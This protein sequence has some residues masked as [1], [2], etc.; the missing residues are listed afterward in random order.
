MEPRPLKTA[1]CS[2]LLFSFVHFGY[3]QTGTITFGISS[4]ISGAVVDTSL[5]VQANLRTSTYTINTAIA[6]VKGHSLVLTPGG[7]GTFYGTLSLTGLPVAVTDTLTIVLTDINGNADTATEPI[8]YDPAPKVTILKPFSDAVARPSFNL[9][10]K[11]TANVGHCQLQVTMRVPVGIPSTIN[12][13]TFTDSVNTTIDLSAYNGMG[14]V[15]VTVTAVDTFN[16]SSYDARN[17]YVETSPYL[18][19]VYSASNDIVDFYND[20]AVSMNLAGTLPTIG[21]ITNSTVTTLPFNGTA[22]DVRLSNE[23]MVFWGKPTGSTRTSLYD[24]NNGNMDS[25]MW[26]LG[27]ANVVVNGDYCVWNFNS[28]LYFRNLAT[29]TT[30]L[31]GSP[32]TWNDV[33]ATGAGA[34]YHNTSGR[35]DSIL[36]YQNGSSTAV[37]LNSTGYA[38]QNPLTDG[39]NAAYLQLDLSNNQSVYRYDA[40][41]GTNS[42]LAALNS[43]SMSPPTVSYLVNNGYTAYTSPDANGRYQAWIRDTSG[44]LIQ[45]GPFVKPSTLELLSSKGQIS[46]LNNDTNVNGLRYIYD[47]RSAATVGIS[48]IFGKPYWQDLDSSWYIALGNTLFRVN[49]NIAADRADSFSVTVKEDSLYSFSTN[50]FASHY[51]T[52]GSL[53][54]VT[55]TKL[56]AHG[57]LILNGSNIGLNQ[58][59]PRSS[60][61]TLVYKPLI[62]FAGSDTAV[63][64]GSNGYSAS[65]AGALLVMHVDSVL[66]TAPQ[67]PV[68][69]GLWTA[70]CSS[71]GTPV[72][73]TISN[74]PATYT[75]TTVVATLDGQPLSVASN[76]VTPFNPWTFAVGPHTIVVIFSNPLGSDTTSAVF[77]IA[78]ASTPKVTLAANPS[79]L[80]ASTQQV[81]LTATNV[82]GGGTAPQYMF[83]T[84]YSSTITTLQAEGPSNTLTIP[85]ASLTVGRNVIYVNMT[86]SDTCYTSYIGQDSIVLVRIQDTAV[87]PPAPAISGLMGAY[88]HNAAAQQVNITNMPAAPSGVTVAGTLDGQ[89]ITVSSA[90]AISLQ[91]QSLNLGAHSLAVIFSDAAGSDTTTRGFLI[92]SVITPVVKLTYTPNPLTATTTD[93]ELVATPL[94]GGKG[95]PPLYTFYKNVINLPST[96][97][98]QSGQNTTTLSVASLSNGN[99]L[100]YVQMNTF[101]SCATSTEVFDSLVIVR[102]VDTTG[103]P[104][105]SGHVAVGPNPFTGTI[106][107]TN[108]DPTKSYGITLTNSVGQVVI[109][110]VV[111]DQAQAVLLAGTLQRGV[112]FLRVVD[113]G[114][115]KV[116]RRVVLLSANR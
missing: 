41:T 24:W 50:D 46:F 53:L 48:A 72:T 69:S 9:V 91:P 81:V 76:G 68:I 73:F 100:F 60:L 17:V 13:G 83:F 88:C 18:T 15:G 45:P 94:A 12:V 96:L 97:Q 14:T 23:G 36:L 5:Y 114:T 106:N 79:T 21:D 113:L 71:R 55:F 78:P 112:Y 3:A 11:G 92:D 101:D 7:G 58:V 30:Q 22:T 27:L 16:A 28:S 25:L 31:L 77:A 116:V 103:N 29:Q 1:L 93:F 85:I 61:S 39:R 98:A 6:S 10:A 65:P 33:S 2:L 104:P 42:L 59:I 8:I 86:T 108:L 43:S 4:P 107:I 115:G 95:I 47:P 87:L 84:N 34:Y 109:T 75:N 52:S 51:H 38:L 110:Q 32:G 63:W 70:Y 90:G 62:N 67:V 54:T 111:V 49:L 89:P 56:P 99:N 64:V 57:S 66:P 74:M 80:D 35:F 40:K 37:Q 102:P 19:P 26:N 82:S 105:Q 20:K 44:N